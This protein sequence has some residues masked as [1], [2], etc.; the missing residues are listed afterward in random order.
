MCCTY[1]EEIIEN[2]DSKLGTWSNDELYHGKDIL[3]PHCESDL[4]VDEY[5]AIKL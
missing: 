2:P 4:R 5:L 3:C 1:C